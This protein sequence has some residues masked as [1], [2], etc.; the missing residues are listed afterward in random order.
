MEKVYALFL[1]DIEGNFEWVYVIPKP[2]YKTRKEAEKVRQELIKTE[3]TV[4]KENSK[5][6]KLYRITDPNKV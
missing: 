1:A 5:I 4:T 6:K 3:K 2:Y